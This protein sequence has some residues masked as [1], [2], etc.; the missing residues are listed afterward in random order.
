MDEMCSCV[1]VKVRKEKRFGPAF[2]CHFKRRSIFLHQPPGQHLS[3]QRHVVERLLR[4]GH[5][6]ETGFT[7]FCAKSPIIYSGLLQ[8]FTL[9]S[10]FSTRCGEACRFLLFVL[11][12]DAN[13]QIICLTSSGSRDLCLG[14]TVGDLPSVSKLKYL[15]KVR[16]LQT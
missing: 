14:R 13:L 10:F 7:S 11:K 1:I 9:L 5:A 3:G 15:A 6:V 2:A 12:E 4:G 8:C 16:T